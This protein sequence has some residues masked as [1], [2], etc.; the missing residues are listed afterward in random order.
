MQKSTLL[1]MLMCLL[2]L[3]TFAQKQYKCS[4]HM[5]FEKSQLSDTLDAEHYAI[6]ID[7][8]NFTTKEI[9]AKTDITLT[10]K[11]DNLGEI[12]LELQDLIVDDVKVD[13]VSV[14]NFTHEGSL[15][16]IPLAT[17]MSSGETTIASIEYHGEPFHEAWGGFHW[18]GEYAFNLGVGF[19]SIPHNLG[20]T[21]FPCIDDFKDRATYEFFVTVDEGKDAVCGGVLEEITDNG[22]G[23]F[24]YH[25]A[26][27]QTIP[28]YLASVAVGDY[29][30]WS[31]TYNGM[32]GD[33]PVEIWVRP[34]D[35]SKV[36]GSFENLD[37]IIGL[38][39]SSFG[40]Y[41]FDRVGYVGTAIG[42]MEHATNIAYPHFMVNG[43][44][45]YE[46][47]IAHELSH[48]WFGD[49]VTCSQAEE[50]WLNEGWAV[51]S[52]ALS[53]EHL[54]G[55]E[56]YI[57]FMKSTHKGVI[58][59]CHT[60]SGDGSYFPINEIPQEYT[61]GMSAYDRGATIAH[62]LRGYLGDDVFFDAMA[63]YHEEFKYN[64]ASSYDLRDFLSTQTSI[65]MTDWFDNW[66][67]H[68]G[69]PNFTVDSFSVSPAGNEYDVT[70]YMKQD[71]HGPEFIGNSNKVELTFMDNNWN[72]HVAD[73]FFD[74][75][76]GNAVFS[77]PF[78]PDL[79]IPDLEEKQCDATTHHA[80]VIKETGSSIFPF[81]Y[82]HLDVVSVED[83]AF[84]WAGHQWAPPDNSKNPFELVTISDYRYWVIDGIFPEGFSAT[85][86]FFFSKSS[87]LDNG[88]IINPEDSVTLL[89]RPTTNDDWQFIDYTFVGIWNIGKFYVEDVQPGLYTIAVVDESIVGTIS[90]KAKKTKLNVSPN[91]SSDSFL[92]E[93]DQAGTLM[94]YDINGKLVDTIKSN[95]VH[96]KISWRPK[97][98][99]GGTYFVRFN[100]ESH[101]ILAVEK[102]IYSH[103]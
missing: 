25:W 98:L 41:R 88:I 5:A 40:P 91:P 19:E 29:A 56:Q 6:Y 67:F 69:T 97:E 30:K 92:F 57:D 14:S 93:L 53:Q 102:L 74:G 50:M 1:L 33:I 42:A 16:V 43:N 11:V 35:S 95:T 101:K 27:N 36:D 94:F 87:Y 39:E 37:A 63:G 85:A 28:T 73:I 58:Q 18:S 59:S 17:A 10:S 54:Y 23:T 24:T 48:M 65:D 49:N 62:S 20:K 31:D 84:V 99:P 70:V 80:N 61:Y 45:Q 60:P 82:F 12:K 72:K 100:S 51:F 9:V 13:G 68:S 7:E 8:L 64:Y 96:A 75:E 26:L 46:P 86:D 89:Y 21:W 83:S 32:N 22:N 81:T 90:H 76:T 47:Y 4:H 55:H 34:N 79:V 77:L 103:D 38:F 71:R 52:D 15:I 44:L 66:V 2:T 78:A 3:S